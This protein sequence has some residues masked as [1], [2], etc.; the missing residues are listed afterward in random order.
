M[1][2]FVKS[3]FP[4]SDAHSFLGKPKHLGKIKL[5]SLKKIFEQTKI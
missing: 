1:V 4:S 5:F 2:E 3:T